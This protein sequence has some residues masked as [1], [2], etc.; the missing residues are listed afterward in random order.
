L[1]SFDAIVILFSKSSLD[2]VTSVFFHVLKVEYRIIKFISFSFLIPQSKALPFGYA[3]GKNQLTFG[4]R[5]FNLVH[6]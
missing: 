1:F 5:E 4:L 6:L 2:F 3:I